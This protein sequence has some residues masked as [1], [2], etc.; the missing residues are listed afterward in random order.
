MY[1]RHNKL[2]MYQTRLGII[3]QNKYQETFKKARRPMEGTALFQL[4]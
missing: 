3:A 2:R 1:I 4:Y